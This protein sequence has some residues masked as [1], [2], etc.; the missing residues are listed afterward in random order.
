MSKNSKEKKQIKQL[1]G[2]KK[3]TKKDRI[4]VRKFKKKQ[5]KEKYRKKE[6]EEK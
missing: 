2:N 5:E 1:V 6:V 4:N 3:E